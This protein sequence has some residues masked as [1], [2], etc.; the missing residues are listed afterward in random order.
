VLCGCA[1]K[2]LSCRSDPSGALMTSPIAIAYI[3]LPFYC[4]NIET[5]DQN[6]TVP[7]RVASILDLMIALMKIRKQTR[8][9][10]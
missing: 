9:W 7:A 2:A 5:I 10:R 3:L 6:I 8:M 1:D 4:G